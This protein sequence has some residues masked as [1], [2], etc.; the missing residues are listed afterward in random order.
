[1]PENPRIVEAW[2]EAPRWVHLAWEIDGDLVTMPVVERTPAPTVPFPPSWVHPTSADDQSA[3]PHTTYQYRVGVVYD[4]D[5]S[6]SWA[7]G[8]R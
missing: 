1:M 7:T 8:S 4:G 5:D 3:D 6:E 2:P